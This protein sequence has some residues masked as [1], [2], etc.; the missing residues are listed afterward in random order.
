MD[1]V[2]QP[3][4]HPRPQSKWFREGSCTDPSINR[5]LGLPHDVD[6]LLQGQQFLTDFH[7]NK[8]ANYQRDGNLVSQFPISWFHYNARTQYLQYFYRGL[9][10]AHGGVN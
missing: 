1:V 6:H 7:K 10:V 2:G 8:V 4:H 3:T 5:G 9:S